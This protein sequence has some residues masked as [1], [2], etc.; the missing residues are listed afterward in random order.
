MPEPTVLYVV[1]AVVVAGLVAWV[2]YVLKTAKEPWAAQASTPL[3]EDSPS[4]KKAAE[5]KAEAKAEPEAKAEAKAEEKAAPEAKA[6]AKDEPPAKAEPKDEH[7]EPK[8]E[9]TEP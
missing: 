3:R 2:A 4:E 6:G 1:T 9:H 8:D 5:A 7:A